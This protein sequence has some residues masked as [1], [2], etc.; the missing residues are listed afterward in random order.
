MCNAEK[1]KQSTVTGVFVSLLRLTTYAPFT[2]PP[3]RQFK[4]PTVEELLQVAGDWARSGEEG[5]AW[6]DGAEDE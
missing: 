4:S 2:E 1:E 3:R 5:D 6:R